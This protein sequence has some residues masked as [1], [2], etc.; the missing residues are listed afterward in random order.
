MTANTVITDLEQRYIELLERK[1]ARLEKEEKDGNV[2]SALVN[3]LLKCANRRADAAKSKKGSNAS[4]KAVNGDANPSD[5][6]VKATNGDT[7]AETSAIRYRDSRPDND[8]INAVTDAPRTIAQPPADSSGAKH[9]MTVLRFFNDKGKYTNSDITIDNDALRALLLDAFAW[10]PWFR[11]RDLGSVIFASH[12]EPIIHNW[13][14]LNDLATNDKSKTVVSDLYRRIETHEGLPDKLSKALTPLKDPEVLQKAA[15]DLKLLLEEVQSTP[16]L[17]TYFSD[18]RTT[19]EESQIVSFDWLWTLF[20]PGEIVYSTTA[21]LGRPQA[22]IVKNCSEITRKEPRTGNRFWD[23]DC[24]TYDWDGTSFDRVPIVLTF[25]YFRSTKPITSLPFYPLRFHKN[26][27]ENSVL[28]SGLNGLTMKEYL[29]KRGK[30]YRALCLKERGKQI[31]DY[32]GLALYQGTGL[33]Q[34]SRRIHVIRSSSGTSQTPESSVVRQSQPK[35]QKI[36]LERVMVDFGSYLQHG[37]DFTDY[38]PMGNIEYGEEDNGACKCDQCLQNDDLKTNQKLHYDGVKTANDWEETQ[39][40]ICP[41]RVLGYHLRSKRW[42]EFGVDNVKDIE[43]LKDSTAF[44]GLQLAKSQKTLIEQLV[45]THASAT[46]RDPTMRD[47]MQ[48]K[49][50]G[51]VILLHGG[52]GTGKTLTAESVAKSTGKPLFA[53]GVSDIGLKP[54]DVEHNLEVL[55]ELAANWQAVMLFDEADVFLESRSSSTA[56]LERNALVSI[57]LRALEYYDGILILTTN[58]IRT[59]DIAVQSRVNFAITYQNLDPAQKTRI[60][61]DFISQLTDENT[62]NKQELLEWLDD[63]EFAEDDASPFKTLNGRQ[64]RN[65]LFSAASIAQDDVDKRLKL[66]HVKR[67]LRE[68]VKFQSDIEAMVHDAR[69]DAEVKYTK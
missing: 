39:F 66:G 3:L 41:P 14:R 49:G 55:F 15:S 38:P 29:M 6:A 59:F 37:P 22:F 10:H 48:G 12:Y 18:V 24:W 67:I 33:R 9:S 42:M 44:R 63:E 19:Q 27:S 65:V 8:G 69:R 4:L 53:V 34:F 32:D 31:F 60:Y 62:E 57:L 50:N 25:E 5:S 11:D 56:N 16:G 1:I 58:R 28:P 13:D 54:A 30:R 35:E 51:L 21:F 40:M 36:K 23:L 20:P 64:I 2:A 45:K 52:P 26:S 17:E 43:K 47:H 61:K 7:P 68:T 46:D